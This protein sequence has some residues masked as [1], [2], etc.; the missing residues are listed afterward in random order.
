M[1]L[2]ASGLRL[3]I[4]GATWQTV[5]MARKPKLGDRLRQLRQERGLS[6]RD[7]ERDFGINSGYLS[8]LERNEVANPTPSV[9]QK[10]ARA[11][12]EPIDVLMEWAGYIERD[13]GGLSP[14]RQRALKYIPEDISDEEL[15]ALKAVL[16]ALRSGRTATA[17]QTHQS[18]LELTSESKGV[19]RANA[20]AVLRELGTDKGPDPVDLD[21]ALAVS[22]LVRAGAIELSLDE[23]QSLRD[24]FGG[25]VDRVLTKLHGLIHFDSG[26]V[27]V[28]EDLHELRKRFVLSH[29]VGHGVLEDHRIVIA[30]LDDEKRLRPEFADRLEREANQFS[31][32][33]LAKGDRL[34]QEF[35]GSRPS[36]QEL[37]RL[38]DR[39][40]I[41]KQATAR[42]IAEESRQECAVAI[43]WRSDGT[44]PV[45]DGYYKLWASPAF[46]KRFRWQD[47]SR[48]HD[49]IRNAVRLA[50]QGLECAP[51]PVRDI[52][53]G[54]VEMEVQG[55]DAV[56]SVIILI[57]P[58]TKRRLSR[59]PFQRVAVPGEVAP[60]VR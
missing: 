38:S 10:I 18:D 26:E 21:E 41:S 32:E 11:Y 31:I 37:V 45:H 49:Q 46:E 5:V 56:Y 17:F 24:R 30:Q 52:S 44:G 42:R 15:R 4:V 35:D 43:A 23:K 8:Q 16:K 9:L 60:N 34:R 51:F 6:L 19:I 39:L 28:K 54:L 58:A 22:K 25:L 27:Y 59:R 47:G 50:A 36:L 20:N 12:G 29:E 53:E 48:P 2:K 55:M 14:N 7:I 40:Q 57:A 33:L 1:L 3:P 13:P